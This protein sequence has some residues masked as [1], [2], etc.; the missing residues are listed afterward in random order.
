M[1]IEKGA[2][3]L[4]LLGLW[5][6]SRKGGSKGISLDFENTPR[7]TK[8]LYYGRLVSPEFASAVISLAEE[9]GV[10]P[11]DL[12]TLFR[13]ERGRSRDKKSL[14]SGVYHKYT[15]KDGVLHEGNF[16]YGLFGIQPSVA[17]WLGTTPEAIYEMSD[18]EQLNLVK[19]YFVKHGWDKDGKHPL[20]QYPK[21]GEQKPGEVSQF[22][23]LYSG[24]WGGQSMV[25][26]G[27]DDVLIS[28]EK[29]PVNYD[30]N[31]DAD[32]THDDKITKK[33]VLTIARG[34]RRA[35]SKK[36]L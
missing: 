18:L 6:S 17:V 25:D 19:K 7:D 22:D 12:M 15:S 11:N 14:G 5:L 33:D 32:I 16:S 36:A 26:A 27:L 3:A 1:D 24:V 10:E 21:F 29:D 13:I 9:L 4:G 20:T 30:R 35:G 34:I 8:G 31:K 23:Q 28:K 2:L